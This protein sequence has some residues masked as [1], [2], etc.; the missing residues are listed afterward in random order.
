MARP[1]TLRG[2]KLLI[3]LGDSGS[4]GV[5]TT[6]CALTTKSFGR[7]ASVNEFSV[8]DCDDP[9]DPVWVERVKSALTSTISGSGTLAKES[10]DIY[11]D[12][13]ASVDPRMVRIKLDYATLPRSYQGL[14][15]MTNFEITG[16]Q[17]G[18]IQVEIELQSSG[19]VTDI[20]P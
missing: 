15:L 13:F 14:Y 12:F 18:L 20:T 8:G 10:I 5:Y 17:D 3:M 16:E 19:E 4:P 1:T 6:P 9:D 2:T 11:E 7:S